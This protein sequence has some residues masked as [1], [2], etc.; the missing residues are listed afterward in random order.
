MSR[1]RGEEEFDDDVDGARVEEDEDFDDVGGEPVVINDDG[2]VD[3]ASINDI[4]VVR[5]VEMAKMTVTTMTTLKGIL[6]EGIFFLFV[7]K[8]KKST[9]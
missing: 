5:N 7:Q 3:C 4:I 8:T 9:F 2:F 6:N 1:C